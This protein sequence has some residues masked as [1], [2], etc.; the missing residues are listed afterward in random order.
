MNESIQDDLL[1]DVL[2]EA[3]TPAQLEQFEELLQSDPDFA[4]R[5]RQNLGMATLL[6][7]LAPEEADRGFIDNVMTQAES[8]GNEDPDAFLDSIRQR[9]QSVI[10]RRRWIA[11]SLAAAACLAFLLFLSQK[12]EPPAPS[13]TPPLARIT[14][15]NDGAPTSPVRKIA[16]PETIQLAHGRAKIQF[17]SGSIIALQAPAT[18]HI[19][20]AMNVKLVQGRLNGW[21]PPSAHGFRVHTPEASLVDLGTSFGI[22][23]EKD[24]KAE[25]VVFDGLV[26]IENKEQKTLLKNGHSLRLQPNAQPEE[27]PFEGSPYK[28]T[29]LLAEGIVS[30]TGAIVPVDPDTPE[31]I[32]GQRDD[33]HVLVSPENRN[34]TFDRPL[35]VDLLK[36]G[37]FSAKH[38][39]ARTQKHGISGRTLRPKR[40]QAPLN[41]YLLHARVERPI[42]NR[43]DHVHYT[44]S[45]TFS[46]PVVAIVASQNLIKDCDDLFATGAWKQVVLPINNRGLESNTEVPADKVTL[47]PDRLTVTIDLHTGYGI[48]EFRVLTASTLNPAL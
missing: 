24:R 4:E 29:W 19:R 43:T 9:Q 17:S 12:G 18:L 46:E 39:N 30:T 36:P 14:I 44:G 38:W 25:F 37:T 35:S 26:S 28:P 6:S 11:G 47:S 15:F 41:S 8:L 3:A 2:E 48:D 23:L 33:Y 22:H 1:A 31:G 40:V 7:S 45:V 10:L 5:C 20:D 21:C 34:I 16:D 13:P 27:V 32:A 42:E